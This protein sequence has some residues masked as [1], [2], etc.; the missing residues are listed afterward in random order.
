MKRL[1]SL[2]SAAAILLSLAACQQEVQ[3]VVSDEDTVTATIDVT[4]PSA[5][6]TKA[7]GEASDLTEVNYEIWNENFTE[8]VSKDVVKLDDEL[9]GTLELKL[10]RFKTYNVLFWAQGKSAKH[11]WTNLKEINIDYSTNVEN[12][13][14]T[15]KVLDINATNDMNLTHKVT[16]TRPFAQMNFAT[17][18]L[19]AKNVNIG[20]LTLKSAKVTV[21]GMAT[22]YDVINGV[23]LTPKEVEF[24]SETVLPEPL[25]MNEK[26]YDHVLL[27]YPLVADGES[28]TV[29][30]KAE[31]EVTCDGEVI[32]VSWTGKGAMNNVPVQADYRTN[33]YG[34]LFTNSGNID[35][36]VDNE[37]TEIVEPNLDIDT[38]TIAA[39]AS[40]A[41]GTYLIEGKVTDVEPVSEGLEKV[42][43]TDA[44][45]ATIT[46]TLSTTQSEVAVKAA[47]TH[48]QVDDV[49]KVIV[50][51]TAEDVTALEVLN[52]KRD[53][54]DIYLD[55]AAGNDVIL[56]ENVELNHGPLVVAEG[57]ELVIDLGTYSI[58]NGKE[59]WNEEAGNW[60]LISVQGGK[61][62]LKGE[63]AVKALENDSYAVDVRDG[64][65]LVIE[66]GNY[67]GNISAIYVYDGTAVI[68]GGKFSVLKKSEFNDDRY[69]LNCYNENYIAGTA[70]ITVTGGT[71]VG[72]NPENNLAEGTGTNFVADGYAATAEGT[73]YTVAEKPAAVAPETYKSLPFNSATMGD[74]TINDVELGGIS[75]VW[76]EDTSNKYMKAN[77]YLS[78]SGDYTTESWL[79][80]PWFDL[81]S[82]AKAYVSF[83]HCA[84]YFSGATPESMLGIYVKEFG[85][86]WV[87][88]EVTEW[89]AGNNWNW[90]DVDLELPAAYVGKY[91][92]VGVK[93]T[94]DVSVEA[95]TYEIKS[96]RIAETEKPYVKVSETNIP[97]SADATSATFEVESNCEWTVASD[98]ADF[99]TSVAGNTVTVSFSANDSSD[100]KLATIT[101]T[102]AEGVTQT[103]KVTQDGVVSA[104]QTKIT[105][106]VVD[107]APIGF[108]VDSSAG[109]TA[110]TS[111]TWDGYTW[112]F[113]ATG[114]KFYYLSS[115]KAIL[116]GKSGAYVLLPAVEG[117]ALK[118]VTMLAPSG[119]SGKVTVGIYNEAGTEV[120]NGGAA[121]I[122]TK[123]DNT[124][125]T[126]TGTENNTSYQLR[127]TNANNSQFQSLTLIYE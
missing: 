63:G 123:G 122:P 82:A 20:D 60:A 19:G 51:K 42:T 6:K 68:N 98:N 69:L 89:P 119:A 103:I 38:K 44:S 30:L 96:F 9:K 94:S 29:N 55:V 48:Y 99:T 120:V 76:K 62:T 102:G 117:K 70:A 43:L 46:L 106:N 75:F 67:V 77:A 83:T 17:D 56:S 12:D 28:T 105:L 35:F 109:L 61:L 58:T 114:G 50:E 79:E 86:E 81:T 10:I 85:G 90:Y 7:Y 72:F 14:F 15:G 59:I 24:T 74:F 88:L 108:P 4:V 33:F 18:D 37:F 121:V 49:I 127:I 100:A 92:Q 13:A 80:S 27:F 32:A 64:G 84:N 87:K 116:F 104:N 26:E 124:V 97:V 110:E 21:P 57:Q 25:V 101:V 115:G 45:A 125:W 3:P 1:I 126:L 112:T 40:V 23:G 5:M 47:A 73:D 93:Y 71:F 8:I 113:C 16:L 34:S 41:D 65:E 66:G 95:G 78:G 107:G 118:S 31:F 11:T 91:V 111:Y 39:L 52:H 53:V 36:T 54:A 2:I 22:K